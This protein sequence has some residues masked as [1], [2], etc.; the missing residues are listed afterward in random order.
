M[1]ARAVVEL[2]ERF[3]ALVSHRDYCL[4]RL[5][6]HWRAPYWFRLFMIV[7]SRAGDSWI[8]YGLGARILLFG[9]TA[10]FAAVTAAALAS[11]L[12]IAVYLVLKKVTRRKRPCAIEP[13]CWARL[14]PPDQYSFPSGH[15]ITAFSIA[16]SLSVFYPSLE[17]PLLCCAGCVAASRIILGM[18]FLSDVVAGAAIGTVLGLSAERMV[19][20][21][22]LPK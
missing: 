7:A 11:T 1:T 12:G 13:H 5:I 20:I 10:R 14:L 16:A 4:M 15:T 6:H 22:L 8:W 19:T 3:F 17:I 18:H 9:G 21:S 2:P